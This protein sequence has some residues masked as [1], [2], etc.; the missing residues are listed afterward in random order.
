[1]L[2]SLSEQSML[3]K[4]LWRDN[5]HNRISAAYKDL[6]EAVLLFNVRTSQVSRDRKRTYP[7]SQAGHE[8]GYKSI[9]DRKRSCS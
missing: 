9:P 4:I 5:V 8:T 6:A 7:W 1:M 3:K 2:E